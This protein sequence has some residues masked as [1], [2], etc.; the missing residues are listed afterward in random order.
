M[1]V[2]PSLQDESEFLYAEQPE[3]LPYRTAEL[4]VD[5]V[6]DWYQ[7][8]A[9]EIEHYARQVREKVLCCVGSL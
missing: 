8:R 2:E 1:V 5:K 3:F 4:A 6:M 7:R 9:E